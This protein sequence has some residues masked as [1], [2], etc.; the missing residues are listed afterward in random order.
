VIRVAIVGCGRQADQ[1]A[2]EI[3][4]IPGCQI[5]GFCDKEELMAKQIAERFDV[6]HYFV[7][8]NELLY[9][10]SPQVVHVTTPPQSHLALG[11]LCL[12]AGA[13]V[14]FEKPFTLNS[15]EAEQ[16]LQLAGEKNLKITVGHNVQ[17]CHAAMKMRELIKKGYLGGPPI[18]LESIWCYNFA[19]PGYTKALLGDSDH[20]VRSLPG[21]MLHN[22]VSH[23]ISK[24]AEFLTGTSPHVIAY[25]YTSNF[26]KR[27]EEYDILDELRAIITDQNDTTAYFTFSTQ[28]NPAIHQLRIYGQKNSLVVDDLHQTVIRV[29]QNYKSYLNHFI[30]PLLE[31]KQFLSNSA[32]NIGKFLRN[33][34]YFEQGR[35]TLIE[36]FYHS[37]LQQAPV[38]IPY[39]EIL[40]TSKIMDSIFEQLRLQ[41]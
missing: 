10:T 22:I 11:T 2:I 39:G 14:L 21:K 8:I 17:F 37:V 13:N 20:W 19:D 31:A 36:L 33:D 7:D 4:S 26:L 32:T 9:V 16:I 24:I 28:I 27:I 29:P 25:G 40:L 35:R 5:V 1:H 6:K 18:H 15:S 23:G 12:E 34:F 38:P 30:P 3:Q 41:E